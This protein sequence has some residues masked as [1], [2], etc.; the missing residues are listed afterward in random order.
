MLHAL[1]TTCV[2]QVIDVWNALAERDYGYT[3]L[4]RYALG[5]S[6]GGAMALVLAKYFP[7]QVRTPSCLVTS[8]LACCI[9]ISPK[10]A[11]CAMQLASSPCLTALVS[12]S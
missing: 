1:L 7:L 5:I 10:L 4:P 12:C 6:S 3:Q 2:P 11:R 9:P 8:A